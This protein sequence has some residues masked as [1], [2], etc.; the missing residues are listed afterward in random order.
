MTDDRN[1][2]W[3]RGSDGFDGQR[4]DGEASPADRDDASP[5]YS[6]RLNLQDRK[7]DRSL[8][9]LD[10]VIAELN[11]ATSHW[12]RGGGSQAKKPPVSASSASR[13]GGDGARSG[14][15]RSRGAATAES[16]AGTGEVA[17]AT[18]GSGTGTGRCGG[19]TT[20]TAEMKAEGCAERHCDR[21][22][23]RYGS[24]E[25]ASARAKPGRS[26]QRKQWRRRR[27]PQRARRAGQ[28]R[29][30]SQ[31]P[32]S[33]RFRRKSRG[34]PWGGQEQPYRR[35]ALYGRHQ[36]A[37]SGDPDLP[38]P[39]FGPRAHQPVAGHADHADRGDRRRRAPAVVSRCDPPLHSHAHG[40]RGRSPTRR[41]D[42]ECRGAGLA[43]QQRTR[44]PDAGRPAAA[45]LVPVSGTLLSFLD[46]PM[47][48]LF[49]AGGVSDP[50]A[51]RLHR[52]GV[53][54]AAACHR[55]HQPAGDGRRALAKRM[56]IRARRT[57]ISIRCRATPR[58]STRWR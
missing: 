25:G 40:R 8:A 35:D 45:A 43:E 4:A 30:L 51:S 20:G 57:S 13:R 10:N 29:R 42:P 16:T 3:R 15:D 36:R 56:R 46:A 47:A 41:A 27:R 5:E 12:A 32:R 28:R 9:E 18:E 14:L 22:R 55:G 11:K 54:A 17:R 21:H 19:A 39:D 58:S 53:R 44:V 31:A 37:G 33:G 26:R 7:V 1:K 23:G 49:I 38:V 6:R 52:R 48:P 2:S 34:G 50:S 24:S